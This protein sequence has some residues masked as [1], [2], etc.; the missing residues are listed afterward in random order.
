M[1]HGSPDKRAQEDTTEWS[2]GTYFLSSSAGSIIREREREHE[3]SPVI[4]PY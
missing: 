4:S 1:L 2:T 3:E